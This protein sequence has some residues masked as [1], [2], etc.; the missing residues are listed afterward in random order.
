MNF[1][2]SNIFNNINSTE[3]NNSSINHQWLDV[4]DQV[5]DFELNQ[6]YVDICQKHG[7]ENKWVL[8]ITPKSNSLDQLINSRHID[9]S[10]VLRVNTNKVKINIKNVET[11]LSKGNCAAVVLCNVS[12]KESELKKLTAYAE[13]GKTKC[14]VLNNR[15]L[16]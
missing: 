7:L 13:L 4:R 9:S 16:H 2:N 11:A 6:Q 14:I 10:K 3:T 12:L 1:N 8:V 5:N 15:V